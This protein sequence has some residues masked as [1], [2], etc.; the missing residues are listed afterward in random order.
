MCRWQQFLFD[1]WWNSFPHSCLWRIHSISDI[2]FVECNQGSFSSG[3]QPDKSPRNYVAFHI[4]FMSFVDVRKVK[5][6]EHAMNIQPLL[7]VCKDEMS[8]NQLRCELDLHAARISYEWVQHRA[9][10]CLTTPKTRFREFI[11]FI[12]NV[13]YNLCWKTRH[14]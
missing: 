2:Q 9:H 1:F 5:K 11:N 8:I 7:L 4:V 12:W 6:I 13:E 3:N 10:V 14:S